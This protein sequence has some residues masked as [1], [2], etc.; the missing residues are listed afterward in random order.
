MD[1]IA[2]HHKTP[3][4]FNCFVKTSHYTFIIL[5]KAQITMRYYANN[6]SN[7]TNSS[8]TAALVL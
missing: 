2:S 4:D 1:N 5:K 6:I 8:F 7:P 3:P